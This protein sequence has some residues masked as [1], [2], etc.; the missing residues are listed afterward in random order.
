MVKWKDYYLLGIA[1]E[2][3]IDRLLKD[4]A[5]E[6]YERVRKH[7]VKSRM[8]GLTDYT[9]ETYTYINTIEHEKE[10]M[11]ELNIPDTETVIRSDFIKVI[12]E[13]AGSRSIK[14]TGGRNL[15]YM[16]VVSVDG[17]RRSST[18]KLMK[19]VVEVES[20]EAVLMMLDSID[21]L[22]VYG[23][24]DLDIKFGI[25][26]IELLTD[27]AV[28]KSVRLMWKGVISLEYRFGMHKLEKR[29]IEALNG[30]YDSIKH[31]RQ[32]YGSTFGRSSN[33][34]RIK[35]AEGMAENIIKKMQ[36]VLGFSSYHI[37]C[38]ETKGIELKM[39]N[40]SN[41][42]IHERLPSGMKQELIYSHQYCASILTGR[43]PRVL[44]YA[45]E[46]LKKDVL[47]IGTVELVF[48]GYS[49]WIEVYVDAEDKNK[50]YIK[51][52]YAE[53]GEGT[54]SDFDKISGL[55]VDET[56]I[57][58]TDYFLEQAEKQLKTEGR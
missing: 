8:A 37:S 20:R 12:A 9:S 42:Y 24:R 50:S 13:N 35:N 44:T 36:G 30:L 48:K 43:M 56:F 41:P 51:F 53:T 26:S 2:K 31:N 3:D 55:L 14:I 4:E 16:A 40:R 23:Q 27:E 39:M 18:R 52:K 47:V 5:A 28:L 34:C 25:D 58:D 38:E 57:V 45:I 1:E 7:S 49:I 19:L 17:R 29:Y 33:C 22:A 32:N 46:Y 11:T 15:K 21:M 10:G 54:G 6:Q